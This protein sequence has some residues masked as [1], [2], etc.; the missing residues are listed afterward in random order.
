M[1]IKS[2]IDAAKILY[3]QNF[4]NESL[5]LICIAIDATASKFYPDKKGNERYKLFLKDRFRTLSEVGFPGISADNICI[6]L[7]TVIEN[8]KPD[9]N[10]YV[11]IEQIIYHLI[12]CGLVHQ[13]DLEQSIEFTEETII[14][15]WNTDKFYIPKNIIWGLIAIVEDCC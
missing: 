13:C 3:E 4:Y 5:C 15:N 1:S 12:R 10:G 14:G 9:K 11:N 8:L 2:F 6:K 7:N